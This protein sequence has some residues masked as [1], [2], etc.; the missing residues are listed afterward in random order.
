MEPVEGFRKEGRLPSPLTGLLRRV[1][2]NWSSLLLIALTGFFAVLP[3]LA[4]PTLAGVYLDSVIIEGHYDWFRPLIITMA[5]TVVLKLV[6]LAI[7]QF[8]MRR[9][10]VSLMARMNSQFFWHLLRL[11][12]RFY[13]QR[14]AGEIVNRMELNS[15]LARVVAGPLAGTIIDLL[16]ML[17]YGTVL[18]LFN[19]P[20]TII[21]T[22]FT[23][24]NVIYLRR[25]AKRR[26]EANI[27][28]SQEA[29][30]LHG[31]TIAGIQS[32]ETLKASGMEDDFFAKW[33]GYFTKSS[34]AG[35]ELQY[36]SQFAQIIPLI[37]DVLTTV[38]ILAVGGYSVIHGKMTIGSLVAYQGLMT[39]FRRPLHISQIS[40]QRCKNCAATCCGS[41]MC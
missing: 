14:F 15:R 2:G 33:M 26:I 23:L 20:L 25:V 37:V 30:K 5:A 3:G 31:F 36:S 34:N 12:T 7:Q 40:A 19:V 35:Q 28:F 8:N 1:R 18:L 29:G 38:L 9:L 16:T 22:A 32:I 39:S 21:A 13:T 41:M 11:P 24:I 27:R 10:Q 17:V 4:I 6:L